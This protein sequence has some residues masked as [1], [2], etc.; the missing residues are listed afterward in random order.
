LSK[1]GPNGIKLLFSLYR[2]VNYV[3]SGKHGH[4][5]LTAWSRIM[6]VWLVVCLGGK[7]FLHALVTVPAGIVLIVGLG[8]ALR[9]GIW[10]W[11]RHH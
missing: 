8:L 6:L 7:V 4:P 3:T 5:G 2:K 10:Y 11:R 9:A 1:E